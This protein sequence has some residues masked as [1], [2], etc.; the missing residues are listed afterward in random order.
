M[1]IR[2]AEPP[3]GAAVCGDGQ[4][5]VP[6]DAP[7]D[8]ARGYQL[9]VVVVNRADLSAGAPPGGDTLG[10]YA[11]RVYDTW[12]VGDAGCGNGVLLLLSLGDRKLFL[13]TGAGAKLGLTEPRIDEVY[14]V[15][16]PA[17]RADAPGKAV[18]A[19]VDAIGRYL[20]SAATA[21]AAAADDEDGDGGGG[22]GGF[23][24]PLGLFGIAAGAI[25]LSGRRAEARKRARYAA[26]RSALRRTDDDR[27]AALANRYEARSCAICLQDFPRPGGGGRGAPPPSPPVAAAPRPTRRRRR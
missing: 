16:R 8:T 17:L 22:G 6:A 23:L 14:A 24:F 9:G 27:S 15:M 13:V 18:E 10:A 5:A 7:P 19:G 11:R 21:A 3:Y 2:R 4:P 26:F 12:G 1:R 20:A 25:A